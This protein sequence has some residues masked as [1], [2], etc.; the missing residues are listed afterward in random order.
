MA[1]R[2][3][4]VFGISCALFACLSHHEGQNFSLAG[5]KLRKLKTLAMAV[6]LLPG[7]GTF[8]AMLVR[9]R[10][11]EKIIP[12]SSWLVNFVFG[13]L[14]PLAMDEINLLKAFPAV[15]TI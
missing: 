15:L 10:L 12:Q 5:T 1:P 6:S 13:L 3:R 4:L 8:E 11:P 9:I 14:N 2:I 7:C